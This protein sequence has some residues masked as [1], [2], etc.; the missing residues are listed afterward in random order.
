MQSMVL[1][2]SCRSIKL[3]DELDSKD[4][5]IAHFYREITVYPL[6]SPASV[7]SP[8]ATALTYSASKHLFLG[9]KGLV[10]LTATL[11]RSHWIAGQSCY[12]HIHVQ[13]GTSKR[14]NGTFRFGF[15]SRLMTAKIKAI[16]MSLNRV[17]SVVRPDTASAALLEE[18]AL[19]D[20]RS[21]TR[22]RKKL[23]EVN[24]ELGTRSQY[25]PTA[26]GWWRGIDAGETLEFTHAIAIP[27]SVGLAFCN[28]S[29]H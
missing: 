14:V 24:L 8:A 11:H 10:V 4:R 6:L 17:I 2:T 1:L 15:S 22:S 5:S 9:G 18:N 21:A 25:E 28:Q 19:D 27:V 7:L 13:N 20:S 16:G 12:V 26:R 23:A 29:I 3:K